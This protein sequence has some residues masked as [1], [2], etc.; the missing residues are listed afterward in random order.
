MTMHSGGFSPARLSSYGPRWGVIVEPV[1]MKQPMDDVQLQL[2]QE[3]ISKGARVTSCG[4]DADENFAVLKGQYVSRPRLSE[5][6]PMQKRHA[7]I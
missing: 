4:F 7:P 6:L 5:K 3:R 1:Q 2:S